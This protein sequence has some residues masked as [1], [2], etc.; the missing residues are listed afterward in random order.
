[1]SLVEIEEVMEIFFNDGFLLQEMKGPE[2]S[3]RKTFKI[4]TQ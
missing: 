4:G 2:G 1:M 3:C